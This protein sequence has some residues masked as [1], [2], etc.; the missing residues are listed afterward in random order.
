[1]KVRM[2]FT[3]T[4]PIRYV[5]HLDFMRYM[6]K[7]VTRSG[8]PGVY[9]A[10]FSPH[11]LMS[12]AD[13]LGVGMESL[14]DYLEVEFAWHDPFAEGNELY[15]L[16]NIGIDN[17]TLPGAPS[18]EELIRKMNAAQA[19]GVK[20][21]TA[22]RIGETKEDKSMAIVRWANYIIAMRDDFH[23]EISADTLTEKCLAFID[24]QAIPVT[25]KTKK[26]EK[27]IDIKPWVPTLAGGSSSVEPF[28]ER[29]GYTMGRTIFLTCAAGSTQNLKPETFSEALCAFMGIDYDRFGFSFLRTDL[30]DGDF[31]SLGDLGQPI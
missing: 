18:G 20:I 22:R 13:P 26:S 4:G 12:F 9:T 10:G 30:L 21:L 14:G 23:P 28:S 6:Q 7:A 19:E 3:K 24:R 16:K 11:L 8:L 15:R 5:G 25:R 27:V 29:K 2:K 1:M 31:R 17:A